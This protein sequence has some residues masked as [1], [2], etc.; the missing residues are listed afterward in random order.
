MSK[1]KPV[2]VAMLCSIVTATVSAAI[3]QSVDEQ[4]NVVFSDQPSSGASPVDLAPLPTFTAPKYRRPSAAA[5]DTAERAGATRYTSLLIA[6]P[7][8]DATLRDNTGTVAVAAT[9]EP[10][11]DTADFIPRP[12]DD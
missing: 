4:G 11:L 7:E 1:A 3:Y 9:I 12:A 8:P 6:Q 2:L 5:E 10:A